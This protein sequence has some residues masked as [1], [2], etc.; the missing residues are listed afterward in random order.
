MKRSNILLTAL[1][2]GFGTTLPAG[3]VDLGV[4]IDTMKQAFFSTDVKKEEEIGYAAASTILGAA[5]PVDNPEVQRYITQVGLWIA[6]QSERPDLHWRF[7]VVDSNDIDAF[8]APGGYVFITRGLILHMNSEAELAGVL[9]HE[10]SHVV[11]KHHL[12]A[13]QTMARTSLVGQVASYKMA[14]NGQNSAVFD[15]MSTAARNL[16]S[17]GLD[18]DDEFQADR[19]GMVLAARA[20]YDPYG[21]IAVLQTLENV[22]PKSSRMQ[23][24]LAT[25]P[26]PQDRIAALAKI[27]DNLDEY[28]VNEE[29]EDRFLKMIKKLVPAATTAASPAAATTATPAT[30]TRH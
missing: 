6:L 2:L 30:V 11:L 27:Q 17:K 26:S 20:G 5:H 16:Y 9:G 14:Q 23:L 3:A 21:L 10:I 28:G 29:G 18:K 22:D 7:A 12:K 8:A 13:L 19:A 1:L 4:I 24:L 25:H 15:K